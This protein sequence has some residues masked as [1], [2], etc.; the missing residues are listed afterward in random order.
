ME[1]DS[2]INGI[3]QLFVFHEVS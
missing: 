3:H 2:A 1:G